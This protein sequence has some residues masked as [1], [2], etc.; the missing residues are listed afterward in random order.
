[1]NHL[2]MRHSINKVMLCLFSAIALSHFSACAPLVIGGAA[3]ASKV[4]IDRR[5]AGIQV[6]DEAIEL[7]SESGLKKILPKNSHIKV[8]SYNRMV[9]LTGEVNSDNDRALAERFVK[10]QDNV[11]SVINDLVIA[12]ET[13][14][15]Q[16]AKDL[17][18]SA[19]IKTRLI[20][21][22]DIHASAVHIV[23]Q[24]GVVY[25]MGRLTNAEADRVSNLV[26]TSQ[27]S[28]IQKVVKVFEVISEEDL[29][30]MVATPLR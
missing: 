8:S 1:M 25:L 17:L 30:R 29:R 12:P 7:R 22:K 10:S 5:T 20:A 21:S 13:T 18:I 24:N 15:T 19:E 26:S 28:G 16:R 2:P 4:V 6:E 3:V 14:L 23:T 9:L 11:K 27:I